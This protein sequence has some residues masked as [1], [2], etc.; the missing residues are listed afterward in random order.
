M[1][2]FLHA[3]CL[4]LALTPAAVP[5]DPRPAPWTDDDED[6]GRGKSKH[7]WDKDE[8]KWEKEERKWV[9]HRFHEEHEDD[10]GWDWEHP[11]HRHPCPPWM[12]GYWRPRDRHY[13]ALVPGD[14]SRIYVLV[15]GRWVLKR[16]WDPNFRLDIEGA[17]ALPMAPPPV[18]LPPVGLSLHLVLLD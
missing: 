14:S 6:R 13:V 10:Q 3:A 9:R 5:P 18:P 1:W 16:V 2:M 8:R 7:K 15:G 12:A 4:T 17:Y 11:R